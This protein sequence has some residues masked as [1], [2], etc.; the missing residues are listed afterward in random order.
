MTPW[1]LHPLECLGGQSR[2]MQ[3]ILHLLG[4]NLQ[5]VQHVVSCHTEYAIRTWRN[6]LSALVIAC[7][8]LYYCV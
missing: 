4:L 7:I 3:K 8:E 1:P 5:T 2:W 6:N